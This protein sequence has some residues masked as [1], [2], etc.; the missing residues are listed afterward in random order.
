MTRL[1]IERERPDYPQV[2]TAVRRLR[3]ECQWWMEGESLEGLHW[4]E[5]NTVDPPTQE[6]IDAEIEIVRAEAI[7]FWLR[8]QRDRLL[9]ETDWIVTK[10]TEL[11][12][13]MP[14]EWKNYRQALRDITE[15]IS[16]IVI[17]PH[18]STMLGNVNW[19]EKPSA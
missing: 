19:P 17:D 15:N 7:N 18:D 6:E 12:Q 16:D 5:S 1:M 10:Y 8:R 14:E 9:Y 3:P 11:G 2:S 13:P 4:D